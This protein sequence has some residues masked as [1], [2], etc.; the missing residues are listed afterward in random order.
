MIER[1]H[2]IKTTI[3]DDQPRSRN[4]HRHQEVFVC[5]WKMTMFL[6]SFVHPVPEWLEVH[7]DLTSRDTIEG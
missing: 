4:H 3:M 1:E 5:M 6:W 7:V 2:R